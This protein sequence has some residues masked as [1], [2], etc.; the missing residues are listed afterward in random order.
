MCTPGSTGT[1]YGVVVGRVVVVVAAAVVVDGDVVEAIE[2]DDAAV[3]VTVGVVVALVNG[4]SWVEAGAALD[5]HADITM[6]ATTTS[7]RAGP[8]PRPCLIGARSR[9]GSRRRPGCTDER[10]AP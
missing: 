2:L 7:H 10:N 3:A 6:P 5:A 4:V 1:T 9:C 8:P